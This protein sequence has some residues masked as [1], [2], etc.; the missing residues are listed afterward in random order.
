MSD[1]DKT[2]GESKR[3]VEEFIKASIYEGLVTLQEEHSVKIRAVEV[4]L[5]DAS[6]VVTSRMVV[7]KV[8]IIIE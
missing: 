5:I 8:K 2:F 4:S 7:S 3:E 1:L 6:T